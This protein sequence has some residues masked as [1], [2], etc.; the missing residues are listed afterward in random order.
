MDPTMLSTA[1]KPLVDWH[2][3]G[4]VL[5]LSL[6]F[7]VGS[8]LILSTGIALFADASNRSGARK[9][10]TQLGAAL[11]IAAVAAAVIFGI[12]VMLSKKK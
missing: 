8:V 4:Q 6:G 10:V 9:A 11:C 7:G 5:L 12:V 2:G 3:L 1:A